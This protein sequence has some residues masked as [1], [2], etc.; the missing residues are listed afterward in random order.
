MCMRVFLDSGYY[1]A[2]MMWSLLQASN[3]VESKRAIII[4]I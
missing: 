3:V 2:R 1:K 4:F